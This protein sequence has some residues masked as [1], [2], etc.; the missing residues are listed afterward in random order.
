MSRQAGE[1]A[2]KIGAVAA[3]DECR[4]LGGERQ[5]T[6]VVVNLLSNAI[7]FTPDGGRIEAR[8]RQGSLGSVVIEIEDNGVGIDPDDIPKV[9]DAYSQVGEPYLRSKVAGTGLGLALTKRLVE[10]HGGFVRLRSAPDIGT[11]V[12]VTLPR[13]RVL[14]DITDR[15]TVVSA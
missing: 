3:F 1:K 13:D 2:L 6:Q 12:S 7:K 4:F 15:L 9:F 10:M 11:T 8:L 14:D 5:I